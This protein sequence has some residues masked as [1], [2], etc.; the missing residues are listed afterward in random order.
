MGGVR[1]DQERL[2]LASRFMQAGMFAVVLGAFV[3]ESYTWLP[4]AVVS[5]LVTE[6]PAILRRN[7]KIVLPVELNFFIVL[8]LFLHVIGGVYGFYDYISWWDHLTH[9]MSASLVAALGFVL[10][11]SIDWYVDSIYLPRPFVAFFVIMFTMAVGVLWELMEW[12][13]DE[14]TGSFLQYSL[15]DSM[16]DMLFDSFAGFVVAAATTHYVGKH[17]TPGRLVESLQIGEARDRIKGI[18]EN[19]KARKGQ[20]D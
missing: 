15:E 16:L 9:A 20:S 5:L 2:T 18:I 4:A 10:V 8:A 3:T 7:L 6:T 11:V 12:L 1:T 17:T 19:R 14:L 13:I